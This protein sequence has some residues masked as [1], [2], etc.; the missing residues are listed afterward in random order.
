MTKNDISLIC[1]KL[2]I[3][4]NQITPLT[5]INYI[6]LSKLETKFPNIS[7]RRFKFDMDNE[8]LVCYICKEC[9]YTIDDNTK[10][11]TYQDKNYVYLTSND[12]EVLE[13]VYDFSNIMSIGLK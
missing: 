6:C 2:G 1:N 8:V 13:D 12:G 10:G 9:D 7:T 5:Q 3:A 4:M 11:D